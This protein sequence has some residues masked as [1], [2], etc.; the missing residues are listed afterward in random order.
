MVQVRDV[1]SSATEAGPSVVR[2]VVFG[3]TRGR[4]ST[5]SA[6]DRIAGEVAFARVADLSACIEAARGRDV[7]LLLFDRRSPDEIAGVLAGLTDPPP[8]IAVIE[9]G[10]DD[11]AA[12]DAF[13]AGVSDCV[14]EGADYAEV[15]PVVALEQIRRWRQVRARAAADRRIAWLEQLQRAVVSEVPVSLVV[16]EADGR[17]VEVNPEF[18]RVF[19][20]SAEA[21]RRARLED[22]VPW[23]LLESAGLDAVLRSAADESAPRLANG[24]AADGSERVFDVRARRLDDAGRVVV[25][26]SDVSETV[27]LSRKLGALERFN[28][29]IVQS[30]NSALVVL[31]E[32]GCITFANPTAAQILE[33]RAERLEG[34]PID[35][36]FATPDGSPSLLARTLKG[37]ERFRGAET[38]I[39]LGSGAL[40]PIGISCT[41]LVDEAG[42]TSGAVAI[43][44]DLSDMKQLE[45]QVLQREKMATIGQLA[46]GVAHE[47]NNPMGFIHANL[48]Q[49]SEYLGD[50]AEYL[51]A[52][53][54]LRDVAKGGD[55]ARI[56]EAARALAECG[57]R[58]DIDFVRSDFAKAVRES[59]EGSERIRHI[60]RDLRDFSHRGHAERTLADVNQC[61]DSTANIVWT[62]MKHSVTL[63]KDY[64]ELPE[65]RCYPMELKQVFMNLLVNAYQ[66]IEAAI[67]DDG[68]VGVI[69]IRTDVVDGGIAVRISDTGIGISPED[70][71]RIFDPFFSTKEVGAGTGLG[72]STS[73]GFVKRHGGRMSVQSEVG[74]GSTFEV[75][76][77][78][79]A[80]ERT[81]EGEG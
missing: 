57:D 76:L 69:R 68:E 21:A 62:M 6:L 55:S 78:L 43:F 52:V 18:A 32:H 75:W 31:D 10:A 45:S 15:L 72:L 66:A 42:E 81:A 41:P 65:L 30:I 13:R 35:A 40:L 11:A 70:Q 64:A 23:D 77:P 16:V 1:Q 22:V 17:I 19:G 5:L 63:E 25:V 79:A 9:P 39:R 60:V 37:G 27:L 20:V 46:A 49:M 44:Q 38:M 73:Y 50:L 36:W 51:E 67:G 33:D 74:R 3:A 7:D 24:R 59:Q 34:R 28:E 2:I 71:Q 61:V 47:I 29:R 14:R 56:E 4:G 58:V 26:L 12:L 48:H 54:G 80:P 53:D 8:S